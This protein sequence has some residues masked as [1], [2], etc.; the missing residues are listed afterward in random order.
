MNEKKV[1]NVLVACE[2]SQ[3]VCKEFRALGHRAFSCDIQECSG[4]FPEWHIQGDVLP[5]LNGNCTFETADTH[6][7]TQRGKW[8]LIIAHPP[9]TY[10]TVTGNS[11]FEVEKYGEKARQRYRDRYEAIVFF[12]YFA[13]CDCDHVAIENP[14]G[15]MNTA[16]RP[17]DCVVHPYHF[18]DDAKKKT[19][20]WLKGLPPLQ[21]TKIITPTTVITGHGTDSPWHAFSWNLPKEERS[22]FRSKTWPGMAKAIAE[23]WSDYLV[24]GDPQ[25]TLFD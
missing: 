8:D 18:G 6:T 11:W 13:L 21:P 17:P 9:C 4:G 14:V 2:E 10:L 19:C 5:I 25:F 1:L 24:N 3:A 23:Q 7:H 16:Y 12:M 20:F 22:R 15:I